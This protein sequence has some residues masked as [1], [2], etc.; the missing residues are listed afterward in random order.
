M[1]K[2]EDY[3]NPRESKFVQPYG[4]THWEATIAMLNDLS[5]KLEALEDITTGIIVRLNVQADVIEATTKVVIDEL[6]KET[7]RLRNKPENY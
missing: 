3:L 4:S 5:E 2:F 7:K 6:K 1:K